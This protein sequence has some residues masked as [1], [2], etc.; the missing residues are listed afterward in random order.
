MII[1]INCIYFFRIIVTL[2]EL[3]LPKADHPNLIPHLISSSLDGDVYPGLGSYC[4][5]PCGVAHFQLQFL[6]C[7]LPVSNV[8][9]VLELH[10]YFV[11]QLTKMNKISV[12]FEWLQFC[13]EHFVLF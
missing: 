3:A 1:H 4:M 7:G 9:C 13:A 10:T 12:N 11:D 2:M 6:Y 5:S 8:T